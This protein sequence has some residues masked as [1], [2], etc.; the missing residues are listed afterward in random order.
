MHYALCGTGNKIVS[1]SCGPVAS[2]TIELS[3]EGKTAS[4][5]CRSSSGKKYV[6]ELKFTM[7]QP[8]EFLGVRGGRGSR[9][10]CVSD[11]VELFENK[12]VQKVH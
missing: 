9:R 10:G 6:I 11:S 4:N 3:V 8:S 7:D 12:S 5:R 2:K 1:E